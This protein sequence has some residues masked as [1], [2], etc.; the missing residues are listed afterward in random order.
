VAR[1]SR[2]TPPASRTRTR[3]RKLAPPPIRDAFQSISAS[4][5]SPTNGKRLVPT[6]VLRGS[7]L[8][9]IGFPIGTSAILTTDKHGEM[10]LARLGLRLPRRLRIVA[11][12]E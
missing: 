6:R 1:K 5:R 12:K 11:T 7:W 9:A 10:A 3:A 4:T 8:T 2:T